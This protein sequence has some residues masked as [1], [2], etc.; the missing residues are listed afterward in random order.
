MPAGAQNPINSDKTIIL[1]RNFARLGEYKLCHANVSNQGTENLTMRLFT[2]SMSRPSAVIACLAI[3]CCLQPAIAQPP[4]ESGSKLGLN[5][6]QPA[7]FAGYT[8]VAP[9]RSTKTYLIDLEG[10]IVREWNSPY[11]AGQD[12]YLLENGNLLRAAHMAPDEMLF[13]GASQGGR[14]Q[15]FTWDGELVWDFKFHDE[16]RLRHH[17]ITRM[18]NGNIM[19]IVWERKTAQECIEAGVDPRSAG[20]GEILVDSLVEVKPNGKTGGDIVWEWH[21]WDHLIQDHDQTKA[22][23]GDVAAHPELIDANYARRN[24]GFFGNFARG[25][26]GRRERGNS[27]SRDNNDRPDEQATNDTVRRLQGLGYVGTAPD[28]G[29]GPVMPISDWTH[30]NGVS[31]NAKL[32]QIMIS[33]REFN[34]VWIVDHSTTTEEAKGHT[35]GRYGKGGDLLYRWGNPAAYR[36]GGEDDQQLFSQHD[37]HWIPEGLPGAGNMLVFNNGGGRNYS[38]VDEIVLPVKSDGSYEKEPNKPFGPDAPHWSYTA[39]KPEEF[40]APLMSGAQ[41]LPNGNTMICAGFSGELFEVTPAKEVVWRYV[42]P[43]D[44]TEG[45]GGPFGPPGRGGPGGGFGPPPGFGPPGDRGPGENASL[46]PGPLRFMLELD[47]EQLK[48]LDAIEKEVRDGLRKLLSEDQRQQWDKIRAEQPPVPPAGDKLTELIPAPVVE[49]LKLNDEQRKSL[50][51]LQA[52]LDDQL[53]KLLADDQKERLK[54]IS[55]TIAQFAA[56]GGPNF[57]PPGGGRGDRGGPGPNFGPPGRGRGEGPDFGPPGGG[58]RGGGPFGGFGGVP[59]SA[60][61]FRA[62][63]YGVDF[64]GLQGKDLTPGKPLTS[65][66]AEVPPS[67]ER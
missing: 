49:Q 55:E 22:N 47:D 40:N 26:G 18:P 44:E 66:A 34:E 43:A 24:G 42:V 7:A 62:Y 9:L 41:R 56:G 11:G 63:R 12:A 13:A 8:L 64:A 3:A 39:A 60:G 67:G 30:V 27:R 48:Q 59:G 2:N 5:L 6:N 54:G 4:A 25:G 32:D 65:V 57:G 53:T 31:Y 21:I 16:L 46:L 45:G 52:T 19:M 28:R 1:L 33:P 14:I 61:V 58:R 37:T 17:A 51:E 15:E 29:R 38:S 50:T 20:D 10:R 35:G 36:A 23:Y